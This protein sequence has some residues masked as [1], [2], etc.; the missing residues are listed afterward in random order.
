MVTFPRHNF[1]VQEAIPESH[2]D[3]ANSLF[4]APMDDFSLVL[5]AW[6]NL[7]LGG[8]MVQVIVCIKFDPNDPACHLFKSTES[9]ELSS[10]F[11]RRKRLGHAVTWEDVQVEQPEILHNSD[12]IEVS[13]NGTGYQISVSIKREV[14]L[15]GYFSFTYTVNF[16][17]ETL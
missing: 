13:A 16:G 17:V 5:A 1:Q 9:E 11:S 14:S 12:Q 10:W 4:H 3:A 7:N 8:L 2:C 15:T 6:D